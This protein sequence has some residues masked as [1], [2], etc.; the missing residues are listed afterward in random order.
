MLEISSCR[1]I[2][3]LASNFSEHFMLGA[4]IEKAFNNPF[5]LYNVDL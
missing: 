2:I 4:F 1:E 5:I 3:K